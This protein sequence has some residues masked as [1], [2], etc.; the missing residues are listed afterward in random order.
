MKSGKANTSI[1]DLPPLHARDNVIKAAAVS[2]ISV[3]LLGDLKSP[4]NI[5]AANATAHTNQLER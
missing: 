1:T 2:A 3:F 5:I 4:A